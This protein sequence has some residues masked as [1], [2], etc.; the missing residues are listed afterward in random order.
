[1]TEWKRVFAVLLCAA[2]CAGASGCFSRTVYVP[3][4]EPVRLRQRV[5]RCRVWARN[6]TGGW[7]A[8]RMD[9]PEGWYA[10]PDPGPAGPHG[11]EE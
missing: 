9:L 6:S 4:G 7:T 11:Q 5:A 1:M 10:L 3:D 8:G 2:A